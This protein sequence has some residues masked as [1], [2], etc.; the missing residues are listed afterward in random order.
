[1]KKLLIIAGLLVLVV[2]VPLLR[3]GG[4]DVE[5]VTLETLQNR[6]LRASIL[7]SGKLTHEEEVMLSTEVIGK[8]SALYVAEGD[9]VTE[10][11]LLLQIDDE[12]PR[13]MVEQ[14]RASTRMQE[15]AIESQK[16]RLSNLE[17]QWERKNMIHERNLLDDDTFEAATN[18]LELARLDV[19]TREASLEQ[20]RA[21]LEEA[22]KNLSK[23]QVYSPLT[24]LVTSLDIKVGETAIS[25]TTNV[26]G[27]SLMTIANPSSIH[28]EVNVDEADIADIKIGQEA[29]IVAIAY[30]NQPMKGIVK[31]IAITAKPP[32]Q[33]STSL[34]FVVKIGITDTNNVVLRPGMSSRAEIFTSANE[35][36]LAVPIQAIVINEDMSADIKEMNVFRFEDGV[37]RKVM[38]EVGIADDTYQ[39]ITSGLTSGDRIITGPNRILRN[40]EDG[41]VVE[42]LTEEEADDTDAGADDANNDA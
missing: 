42:E 28:T 16:L 37:A 34:S 18:E 2:A 35:S 39:Q 8:V 26:P 7:A 40:L 12:G 14:Q 24:G 38:V 10:G 6:P 22:E 19:K 25:S 30:P 15:I 31:E 13:A 17:S 32:T 4:D 20:A 11:E 1:M 3:R 33:T 41:D 23:T 29:E 9:A 5:Q 27:S 36:V 21:L